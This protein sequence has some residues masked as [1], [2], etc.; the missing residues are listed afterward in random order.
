MKNGKYSGRL[1]D[2]GVEPERVYHVDTVYGDVTGDGLDDAI[3]VLTVSIRGTAIPYYVY[4]YGIERNQPKLLWAFETGDRSDAGL[5][6]VFAEKGDLVV[7][8]YGANM[9][10]G[11][12]YYILD[13]IPACC[14]SHYTRSRYQWKQNRFRRIDQLEVFSNEGAAPYLPL[15]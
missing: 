5:C 3:V 12:D 2:G 14:P 15:A 13:E 11:G 1:Q 8:L 6:R 4:I 9:F 7:E 10:V